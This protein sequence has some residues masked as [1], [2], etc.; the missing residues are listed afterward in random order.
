MI[1]LDQA[2]AGA[3]GARF[4]PPLRTQDPFI[5]H[6][7]IQHTRSSH[8]GHTWRI[9]PDANPYLIF[10]LSRASSGV[11]G[12]CFLVGPRSRF[13]D[14]TM[15]NRILTCGARLRPGALPLLTRFPA[16]E[17]TDRS[18][19]V[20]DVFAA[21]GKLLIEQLGEVTSPIAAIRIISDFLSRK[22]TSR[23]R[24]VRLPLDRYARV[25]DMA[26]Q[27]GLPIRTL[28][29]R[30]MQH[31]GLSPKRMIRIERLHRALLSS[32]CRSKGWGEIAASSGFADQA[33]MIREFRDLLGESPTVWRRRSRLPICSRQ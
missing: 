30:L 10:V 26:A 13:A 18:V 6:F 15:A 27:T 21:P 31:V 22:W 20:E 3:N 19:F 28:R 24:V 14:V 4:F 5:D 25:E 29:S 11:Q 7:W 12:R 16:S 2:G 8:V 23:N 32:E 1:L 9:V 17:F 33:H